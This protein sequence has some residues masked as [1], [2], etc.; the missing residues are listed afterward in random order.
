MADNVNTTVRGEYATHRSAYVR[1][2]IAWDS[3]LTQT[4][5]EK[6]HYQGC[7][8]YLGDDGRSSKVALISGRLFWFKINGNVVSA[9]EVTIDTG[10]QNTNRPQAW[11][12]QSE[13]YVIVQDGLSNPIFFD[14]TS[15]ANRSNFNQ[16][17]PLSATTTASFVIPAIGVTVVIPFSAVTLGSQVDVLDI[18]TVNRA[19]PANGYGTFQVLSISAL[20]VTCV[21]LT[22]TPVGG[23]VPLGSLISWTH[24]GVQ[25]PPGRVGCYGLSRNWMSLADGKQFVGGDIAGGSSGT[26]ANNYRDAV[27]NITENLY[28]VGGGNFT[29][30]GSVG[31]IQAM[32]FVAILD[33]SL[34]QGPLQ[35]FTNDRV[36]SCQ[37]PVDRLTWQ[38]VTNPILTESLI[39]NGA[40]G[41]N[42][43]VLVNGDTIFRSI[44]GIRSL[45]LARRDFNTWGNVP[46]SFEVIKTLATDDPGLLTYGSAVIFDN[47]LLM[48]VGTTQDSQGVYFRGMVALNFDPLSSIRGKAPSAWDG[49]WTGL[50]VLQLTVGEV[51]GV[52]RAFAFV[53]NTAPGDKKIEFWEILKSYNPFLPAAQQPNAA[54]ADNDGYQDFP[55]TWEVVSPS[56]RF[57]VDK[58]DHKYMNLNN[59]EIWVG[60]LQGK[61][62]FNVLYKPD[63]Y[64]CWTPWHSWGSCQTHDS[65]DSKPGFLPRMGFGTPSSIPCDPSSNRLMRNG[66]TFQVRTVIKGHCVLLGEFYEAQVQPMEKFAFAQC[67]PI[68]SNA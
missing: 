5:A 66:F 7:C 25:L 15:T 4:A 34:G 51:L 3:P 13:N 52:E 30:P 57:G 45:I 21:N 47:R 62:F 46:I 58:R 26:Q 6:G 43:T 18:I 32:R 16:P 48:T 35:V 27:L 28:L 24:Q 20:D 68:C 64:W 38:S 33:A 55:I 37:A 11:L 44:D 50:N 10:P 14:G 61:V 54:I 56:L 17:V 1:R 41:Q 59:G 19:S 65:T 53:L 40:K 29:V 23:L 8:D 39:C 49:K 36:F 42:S 12:W 9:S 60:D 31:T 22:A 2:I 67:Q 63:Q